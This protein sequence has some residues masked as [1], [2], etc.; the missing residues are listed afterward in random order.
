MLLHVPGR[1]PVDEF[2]GRARLRDHLARLE[3]EDDRLRALRSGIDAD[4]KT[5]V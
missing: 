3:V 1:Q 5:H 4:E 2:M